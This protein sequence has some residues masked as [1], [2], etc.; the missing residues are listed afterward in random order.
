MGS[1][2][3]I[4]VLG[5]GGNRDKTKRAP[6]GAALRKGCDL[7]IFTS[8]NPRDEDPESILNE[9]VKGISIDESAIVVVDRREAIA[10]AITS[11]H[12]GD[13]VVVLGKGHETGQEIKGVTLPFDDREELIRAIEALT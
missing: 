12:K 1:H 7:A 2:R 4:G 9:M 8:D 3:I 13:V 11:A 6:M 10:T 5:C